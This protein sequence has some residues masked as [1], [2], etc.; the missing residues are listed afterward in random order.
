MS[1]TAVR[2]YKGLIKGYGDWGAEF[3]CDRLL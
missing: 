2:G 3:W 1:G